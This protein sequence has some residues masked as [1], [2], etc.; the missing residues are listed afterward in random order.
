[1]TMCNMQAF[2]YEHK[3]ALIGHNVHVIMPP[4]FNKV[5]FS[6]MKAMLL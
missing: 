6:S 1:M 5:R 3:S 2:G 4:P